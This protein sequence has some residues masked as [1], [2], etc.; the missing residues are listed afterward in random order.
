MNE[1]T[2][3]Q[4]ILRLWN[5]LLIYPH[6]FTRNLYNVGHK[7]RSSQCETDS[8]VYGVVAAFIKEGTLRR[9]KIES[10]NL[11]NKLSRFTY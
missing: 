2:S 5:F 7:A 11:R 9:N 4:I 1:F 3:S 6:V 8:I 10:E